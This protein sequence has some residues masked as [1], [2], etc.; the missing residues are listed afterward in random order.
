MDKIGKG[1]ITIYTLPYCT[2][3]KILKDS[4]SHLKLPY[5]E[6]NVEVYSTIGDWLELNLKTTSY[7]I[8]YIE[9]T[10]TEYIYILSQTNLESL[11]KVRIFTDINQALEILLNY[12]YEI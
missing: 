6:V 2:Y 8:I 1:N 4:L 10:P 12:Y 5:K 9:I 7:P 3:C 11:N